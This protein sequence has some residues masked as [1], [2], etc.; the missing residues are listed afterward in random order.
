MTLQEWLKR[1]HGSYREIFGEKEFFAEMK[2]EERMVC[3]FFRN[4]WPCKVSG[5]ASYY[6]LNVWPPIRHGQCS[7]NRIGR[8]L[9]LTK[10]AF[11]HH[12]DQTTARRCDRDLN[13]VVADTGDGQAPGAPVPEAPGDQVCQGAVHLAH[14]AL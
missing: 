10:D 1:G 5:S 14:C 2:G 3:H 11:D 13:A 9:V 12:E 7:S 6:A 4:N 8:V